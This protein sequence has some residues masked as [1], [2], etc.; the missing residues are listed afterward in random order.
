LFSKWSNA[1]WQ[2]VAR[3]DVQDRAPE[4]PRLERR[5]DVGE[6]QHEHPRAQW[7]DEDRH[8]FAQTRERGVRIAHEGRIGH[9][10]RELGDGGARH[11]R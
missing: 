3:E 6:A 10:Q 1:A 4:R 11:A 8:L 2:L 5:R 7:V 9:R